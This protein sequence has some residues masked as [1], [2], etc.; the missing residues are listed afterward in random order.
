MAGETETGVTTMW[1]DATLDTGDM[2][3]SATMPIEP[4]DTTG[5]L[6]PKMAQLGAN[7]LVETLAGLEVGTLIRRKQDDA[8]AT[9]APA[10]TPED[11]E[12]H[13]DE[14]AGAICARG[15]S[16]PGRARLPEYEPNA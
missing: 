9:F 3:L 14:T 2:L 10:L 13:W 4:D 16:A 1:M 12:V 11:A 8:E 15:A 5:T 7:L 6:T